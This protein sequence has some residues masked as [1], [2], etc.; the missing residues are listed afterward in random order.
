MVATFLMPCARRYCAANGPW[1]ASVV[2]VRKYVLYARF[3][4]DG[5]APMVRVGLVLAGEIWVMLAEAKIGWVCWL[6]LEVRSP[7]TPRTWSSA[8]SLVAAFLPTSALASSSTEETSSFQPGTG[9]VSLACL[10]PTWPGG[11]LPLPSADRAP[12]S[13]AMTPILA[14]F[15]APPV[16]PP[17]VVPESPREPQAVRAS[18]ATAS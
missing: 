9:W 7:T 16:L 13:G 17:P 4:F 12:V 15:V 10:T 8:A 5:S 18:A 6:T 14:V 11:W 3:G 1:T 2:Q